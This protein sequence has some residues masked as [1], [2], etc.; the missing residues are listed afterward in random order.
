MHKSH[1]LDVY[2]YTLQPLTH[3]H[4]KGLLKYIRLFGVDFIF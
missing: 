1:I 2:L 3:F 4:G